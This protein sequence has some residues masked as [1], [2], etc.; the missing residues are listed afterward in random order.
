MKGMKLFNKLKGSDIVTLVLLQS[1][2]NVLSFFILS[3]T[4]N[5]SIVSKGTCAGNLDKSIVTLNV[6]MATLFSFIEKDI[7][8]ELEVSQGKVSFISSSKSKNRITLNPI[9]IEYADNDTS[10]ILEYVFKF[11]ENLYN[12]NLE[13]I[14]FNGLKKLSDVAAR[15]HMILQITKNFATLEFTDGYVIQKNEATPQAISGTILK[16]LLLDGGKFYNYN[17]KLVYISS[18]KNTF[19]IMQRYLPRVTIDPSIIT[20]GK[21]L[22]KYT[23]SCNDMARIISYMGRTFPNISLNFEKGKLLLKNETN[24]TIECDVPII[25]AKTASLEKIKKGDFSAKV[26]MANIYLPSSI[27]NVLL[28][29]SDDITIYIKQKKV[30]IQKDNFYFIFGRCDV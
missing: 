17:D 1:S 6:N 18:L 22:E 12:N 27:I 7:D 23:I 4:I 8:F 21:L 20:S 11:E 10:T 26:T 24:E 13:E 19:V 9:S 28:L 15:K 14:S 16:N 25:E 30:I 3:K 2:V 5:Y 29:F